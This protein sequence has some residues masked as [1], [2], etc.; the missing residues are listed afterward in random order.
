MNTMTKTKIGNEIA[1]LLLK[2]GAIHINRDHPFILAA[3][4]ASPVYVDVRLL[5]GNPDLRR[6]VIGLAA[7]YVTMTFSPTQFDAI[8]GA[9]TAGIP[10]SAWL[11]DKL[12]LPLRYVRKHPLGFGHNAQVEGGSVE[13]MK[14][15]LIDDL[16]TDGSSKLAFARGIRAAGATLDHILTIFYHDAFQSAGIRLQQAALTL[17]PLASWNNIL[18]MDTGLDLAKEDRIEI[19]SFLS[20]PVAWSTRHGGRSHAASSPT[21]I[22]RRTK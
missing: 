3:G 7:Q 6:R 8:I 4:W 1:S 13:G 11:S 5:I 20:D 14:V 2:A 22:E 19:E 21:A 15:L 17:H 12:N 10:F 18:E 9:E 16:T